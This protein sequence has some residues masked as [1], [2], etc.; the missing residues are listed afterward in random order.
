M[1]ASRK[2][3]ELRL[4]RYAQIPLKGTQAMYCNT[5]MYAYNFYYT[6]SSV[7]FLS[8]VLCLLRQLGNQK[9]DH[10]LGNQEILFHNITHSQ[11]ISVATDSAN[12]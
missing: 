7:L 1:W 6:F 4:L 10:A 3:L 5:P 11:F 2:R 8:D 9:P 12:Y